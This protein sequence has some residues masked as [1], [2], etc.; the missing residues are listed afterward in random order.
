V[1]LPLIFIR[2]VSGVMYKQ[3]ALVVTFSLL[4]SLVAA[5][6]LIPML[7]SRLLSGLRPA[8]ELGMGE[9]RGIAGRIGGW[10][11]R[12]QGWYQGILGWALDHRAAVAGGVVLLLAASLA[13]IPLIGSELMPAT[14]EGQVRVSGEMELGT[15]LEITDQVFRSLEK[16]VEQ[17]VPDR[18]SMLTSVGG[19]F[20]SSG[21]GSGQISIN[22]KPR[23][24]RTRSDQEVAGSLRQALAGT[25][26]LT[27]RTRTGQGFF[28]LRAGSQNT[29]QVQIE[30]RGYDMAA[31]RE[32]AARVKSLVETVDGV[33]DAQFSREAGLP[34]EQVIVDRQRAAELDLTLKQ[35][36]DLLKTLV[37]G[38]QAGTYREAGS[39]YEILVRLKDAEKLSL[40]EILEVPAINGEGQAVSL[41]NL[42]SVQRQI[43]PT[44]IERRN[45]ERVI[46]VFANTGGR[47]TAAV[48][49]RMRER[50]R[51]VAL[52]Q[53]FTLSF[54]GDFEQQQ[55]SFREIL[56]SVLLSLA[57]VYMVM[58]AL[59]ESLRDPFIVMFSVPLA[60]IGVM[61]MLFLTRTTF[62]IQTGIGALM[63]GGIVVNNAILL[64]DYTN[65]LRRRDGLGLREALLTA[66]SRRL[67]PVLMTSLTTILGL[68]P[69]AL[70]LGEGGE[71]QAPLARTVIG[72]LLSSTFITLVFIPVVY[73]TL[74][75][76]RERRTAKRLISAGAGGEG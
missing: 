39:E 62:N 15:R 28:L 24:Q 54:V 14:D 60:A 11:E 29:E 71:V 66:C 5:L 73:L 44:A 40:N 49:S 9:E 4:C 65:L 36:T 63:L 47:N 37:A 67:R 55:E 76:R 6:T 20:R 12:F 13:L 52:P 69:L 19:G 31:G 41:R 48:I 26:G 22:L 23:G 61:L 18:D 56:L 57:L 2:G 27:L 1:F 30:I 74:E 8:A 16:K 17:S 58:V 25:P 3:L 34:E 38:T 51:E 7:A 68:L 10:L 50:L 35:V 70:G 64:V 46:S 32:L 43:G 75:G 45:Q 42:V 53:G 33:T 72:G 21:S 59:Y